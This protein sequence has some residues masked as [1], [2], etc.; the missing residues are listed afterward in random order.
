MQVAQTDNG[1]YNILDG[2]NEE[3]EP[4]ERS[5]NR[6]AQ[7]FQKSRSHLKILNAKWRYEASSLLRSHKY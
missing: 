6:S 2:K 1:V 4:Y 3:S 7:I 5:K